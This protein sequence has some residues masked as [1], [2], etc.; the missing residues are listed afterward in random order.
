MYGGCAFNDAAAM[1]ATVSRLEA[2]LA[3]AKLAVSERIQIEEGQSRQKRELEAEITRLRSEVSYHLHGDG[4]SLSVADQLVHCT[5]DFVA[6]SL[7]WPVTTASC[8]DM[9]R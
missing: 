7:V 9:K 2:D 1:A 5:A 3:R 6:L 8:P 4:I